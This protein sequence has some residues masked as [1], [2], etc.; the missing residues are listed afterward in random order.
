MPW[1]ARTPRWVARTPGLHGAKTSSN[2][3]TFY[4]LCVAISTSGEHTVMGKPGE[5]RVGVSGG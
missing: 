2:F 5:G 4:G 1:V 3:R